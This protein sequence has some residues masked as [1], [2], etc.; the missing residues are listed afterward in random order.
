MRRI[1]L[2]IALLSV[3][4]IGASA[5]VKATDLVYYDAREFPILGSVCTDSD[6]PFWRLP[7]SLESKSR[8]E[9]F[10][11]GKNSAGIAVRF[12]TDATAIGASWKS[13]N[14]FNMNHMTPTGIRGLDLYVMLPDS[15]W[16][17]VGSARPLQNA[18]STRTLIMQN[19]RKEMRDYM[20]YLSLYDGVDSLYIGVDSTATICQPWFDLP[21]RVKPVVMYGTSVL[22]GGC[23]NRPGMVHTSILGRMLNREVY[24]FGFSGNAK[25]DYEIAELMATIDAGV[26]VID[27]LP[28][29]KTPEI[30]ERM[31]KFFRIIRDRRPATPVIFVE[32]V[33]FP[34]M[35]HDQETYETIS[36]KNRTL[37]EIFARLKASGEKNIYYFKGED[38]LGDCYEGTVDNYHLTD[39]GFTTFA[40]NFYPLLKDILKE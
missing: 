36:E 24:N 20:L 39:L 30:K 1:V 25:L 2:S 22:Q 7:D 21:S 4:A 31:E 33:I 6:H 15:T 12:A 8:P 34:I 9:L 17:T 32:S 10:A 5:A 23:A 29:L 35:R 37:A 18:H 11:L 26:Y 14:K 13:L 16:T 40:R 28:N 19:M 3:I 38:I 27:A